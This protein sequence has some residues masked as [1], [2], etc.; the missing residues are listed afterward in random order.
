[1]VRKGLYR[2]SVQ[3][4]HI[5]EQAKRIRG[6]LDA[7]IAMGTRLN[8]EILAREGLLLPEG[9]AAGEN[10]LVIALRLEDGADEAS[11]L[12][13]VEELLTQGGGGDLEV[14]SD[15]ER[16]L[17]IHRDINLALVSI[18]GQHAREVV[19]KLLE[20]GVHVHLFSDHVPLEHEVEMKRYA[21]EKG[22]LLMGPEAGTSIIGGAA[23][24]FA[25]SVRRGAIGIV[26]ASGTGLQEVSTLIHRA[27]QGISHGIGVGGRDLSREVGGIM[28]LFSID[29]LEEDRG[30]EVIVI[31]SK[32]PSEDIARKVLERAS[33]GSK[34]YVTCFVGGRIYGLGGGAGGRVVQTRTLHAAAL[35][36]VR[37]L[38]QEGYW[39]A[40]RE[41]SIG[42]EIF[43]R[44]EE[45]ASELREGQRYVRGLFVGG[46]LAYEAMAI[47][48]EYVGGI[49]SNTPLREGYRL[50]DPWRS[51]G[52]TVIDL[53]GEE[54][55][56]GRPHPM[57]DPSVRVKRVVEEAMDPEV[58][59]IM[60]DFVLGYGAH[61]DPVG[62]HMEALRRA[63][64][65]AKASGR[66]I[67][68]L[69]HVVGTDE[70]PQDLRSQE[71]ALRRLGA[72]VLPT[73]ALMAFA[74]AMI[75][76]RR[77]DHKALSEFHEKFAR[78]F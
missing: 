21:A 25:N 40:Y 24:A 33:A 76:T 19:M 30:T 65:E 71:E 27:G 12:E 36:S 23:I 2:D 17:E 47:L 20:K 13:R 66:R 67:A 9:E 42:E 62:A 77:V 50:P 41:L 46:T 58:A 16:A 56:E 38:D 6:V 75:A 72:I 39:R 15:L 68:I 61:P 14:Y 74:A 4:L 52:N 11:I 64:E 3:L 34:R 54:F 45:A 57:I 8:K 69:A 70:D 73:N 37:A 60:L 7:A 28:T 78:G 10:D 59:V 26:S 1:V 49:W 43:S 18:P 53:G 29:V 32:P 51:Y 31:I 22:L 35:E 55:T 48:E 63:V 5:S 44:I